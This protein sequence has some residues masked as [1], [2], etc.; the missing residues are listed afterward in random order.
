[1]DPLLVFDT[2]P[3]PQAAEQ[4]AALLRGNAII[5]EINR[6]VR[7]LDSNYLG[8]R[9][10]NP[11]LLSLPG[12]DFE[13]ARKILE[14]QTPVN[15]DEVDPEYHLLSFSDEELIDVMMKKD[16]WGDYNYKLAE[17]LLQRRGVPIPGV[18][19]ELSNVERLRQ[20]E[21]AASSDWKILLLGYFSLLS[22][23]MLALAR[24][25]AF[26]L[27]PGGLAVFLGWTLSH[28]RRTLSTGGQVYYYK[29]SSR[30]HG[31]ILFW[32]ALGFAA[33]RLILS[34]LQYS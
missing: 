16:E 10:D 15:P 32:G 20:K 9:F 4:A 22:G 19:I 34:I 26:T 17:A 12:K 6:D 5:V 14:E 27:F 33:L 1:M 7:P 25:P 3:T 18:Q 21:K 13:K 30:L 28:S 24:H 2:Y 8:Q 31:L 11:Y 29:P 23:A